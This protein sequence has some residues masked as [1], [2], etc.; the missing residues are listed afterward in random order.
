MLSFKQFLFE[1]ETVVKQKLKHLEH[2]E[3]LV[4]DNQGIDRAVHFLTQLLS[5]TSGKKET[6]LIAT[7]KIDGAPSIV[8]GK[9]PKNELNAGQFFVGTKSALSKNGKRYTKET[10]NKIYEENTEG[11]AEKLSTALQYLPE[12]GINTILQGDFL[13]TKADLQQAK[14]NGNE[15][16]VFTPNVLTYAVLENSN[17][18]NQIKNAK[19]GVVFHTE[20]VGNTFE[21][22]HATYNPNLSSLKHSPNVFWRSNKIVDATKTI[23]HSPKDVSDINKLLQLVMQTYQQID[24]SFLQ[25]IHDD[26][27]LKELIK[28]HINS[29][30]RQG[31]LVDNVEQ[32]ITDFES[33]IQTRFNADIEKYK[34]QA[35]KEEVSK[36]KE[37]YLKMIKQTK[38][39][40]TLLFDIFNLLTKIKL[41]ILSKLKSL[42]DIETFFKEEGKYRGTSGEGLVLADSKTNDVVK[43]VDRLDFSR[44]NFTQPKE[45]KK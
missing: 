26:S 24:K 12:I 25:A 13:F 29:K 6:N 39:Q 45:W 34:T 42:E 28:M 7:I 38:K 2:I 5:F 20:Y 36:T 21:E 4:F 15:H 37:R 10:A 14:I 8:A 18:G 9:I 44:I 11:L 33:Y 35:K 41:M 31:R 30:I 22:M 19:M 17:I 27:K 43:L 1:T 16:I 32:H 3:D 40:L 23:S